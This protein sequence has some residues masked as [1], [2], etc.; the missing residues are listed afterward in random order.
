MNNID[1]LVVPAIAYKVLFVILEA[2]R[3]SIPVICSDFGGM[4]EVVVNDETGL[5]KPSKNHIALTNAINQ[6]MK[7]KK[8]TINHGI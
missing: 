4:K 3:N 8:L 1:V 7:S 5:I 6:L 2:M